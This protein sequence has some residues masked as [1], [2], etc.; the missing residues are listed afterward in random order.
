MPS[1]TAVGGLSTIG[2]A[3][4]AGSVHVAPPQVLIFKIF[5]IDA[6]T[7]RAIAARNVAALDHELVN[8]AVKWAECIAE[9]RVGSCAESAKAV[10]H[11]K[12][13]CGSE[14]YTGHDLLFTSLWCLVGKEL[15]GQAA[16]WLVTDADVEKHT[17]SVHDRR[18][19]AQY[20]AMLC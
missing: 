2:H 16:C 12:S 11:C 18:D 9:V 13:E 14:K 15:D 10:C 8:Y 7:T 17:W 19:A 5:S 6:V 1:L 4:Q 20:Y 3:H